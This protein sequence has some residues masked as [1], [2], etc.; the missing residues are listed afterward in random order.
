MQSTSVDAPDMYQDVFDFHRKFSAYIG[1]RPGIP[2]AGTAE[3]RA[4]L[5]REEFDELLTAMES[6]DLP[7]IAD[8]ALDLVYVVLGTLVSYGIDARPIWVAIHAANMAKVGG[9]T[10]ADGKVMKPP[11]WI[12][13]DVAGLLAK[14]GASAD[15]AGKVAGK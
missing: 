15:L 4:E 3:L 12:A 9:G 6:G 5:I 10:R 13:P 11:G 14:Q 2:T 1:D 8:G 7:G